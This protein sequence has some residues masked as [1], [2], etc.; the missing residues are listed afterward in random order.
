MTRTVDRVEPDRLEH[1]LR[2]SAW[3]GGLAA[4]LTL[5][6]VTLVAWAG[7]GRKPSPTT[8][9]GPP[10]PL[11][12]L[13]ARAAQV[14]SVVPRHAVPLSHEVLSGG[15]PGV[16][17]RCLGP[18]GEPLRIHG[19]HTTLDAPDLFATSFDRLST[20]AVQFV[21]LPGIAEGEDWPA[22]SSVTIRAYSQ[23]AGALGTTLTSPRESLTLHFARPTTLKVRVRAEHVEKYSLFVSRLSVNGVDGWPETAS[24][25]LPPF[26]RHAIDRAGLVDIR[27][28][29]P[30]PHRVVLT[31]ACDDFGWTSDRERL[32]RQAHVDIVIDVQGEMLVHEIWAPPTGDLEVHALGAADGA[33]FSLRRADATGP[34]SHTTWTDEDGVLRIENLPYGKYDLWSSDGDRMRVLVPSELVT[35][36]PGKDRPAPGPGQAETAR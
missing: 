36:W 20:A 14:G 29:Q 10:T 30:G 13:A 22:D 7:G 26:E 33:R 21:D 12:A 28:V 35:F 27:R 31:E 16:I 19:I 11:S 4:A 18:E 15:R 5:A 32:V 2:L 34:A 3:A 6:S 17:L 1:G 23:D 25:V 8:R 24:H 9:F